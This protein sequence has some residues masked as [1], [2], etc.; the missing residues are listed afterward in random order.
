MT[1]DAVTDAGL[2]EMAH[3]P[4]PMKVPAKRGPQL[5]FFSA[6]HSREKTMNWREPLHGVRLRQRETA[7]PFQQTKAA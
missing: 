1:W 3:T 2:S 6:R 5:E 4:H 7:R